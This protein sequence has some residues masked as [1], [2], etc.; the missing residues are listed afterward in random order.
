MDRIR[1][2]EK[3][4]T[5]RNLIDNP[6]IQKPALGKF[7][8]II[9]KNKIFYFLLVQI[10]NKP[11]VVGEKINGEFIAAS[12]CKVSNNRFDVM[13]EEIILSSKHTGFLLDKNNKNLI[14]FFFQF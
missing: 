3:S 10:G 13:E 12:P 8:I 5:F 2:T 14:G 1:W 6:A 4:I 11:I 9:I 7:L